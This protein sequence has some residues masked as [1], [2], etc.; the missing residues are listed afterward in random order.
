MGKFKDLAGIRFGRLLVQSRAEG[1][2]G[3]TLWKCLCDCGST[4]NI[5]GA[6]LTSGKTQSCGCLRKEVLSEL[7]TKH[8]LAGSKEYVSWTGI[9]RRCLVPKCKGYE[10][11]GAKG[12]TVAPEWI[13]SFEEFYNHI[14]PIPKDGKR[15]SCDRIDNNGGYTPGN[16]RWATYPEQ[17]KNRAKS[18]NNTSGVT[19]VT[20]LTV[21]GIDYI[22]A[23]WTDLN[24]R[25]VGKAF[26]IS[27]LGKEQAFLKACETREEAI[28]LLNEQGAGYTANH[29]K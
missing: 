18:P 3:K 2:Y 8:G 12:I 14:G 23:R 9:L 16:V 11:Y 26:N 29:G 10:N 4:K 28:R 17:A 5:L 19:G 21:S 15:Y 6:S 27:K 13:A 24:G 7:K 22:M 20:F 25:E 1:E